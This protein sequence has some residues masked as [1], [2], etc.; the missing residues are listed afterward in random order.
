M[1]SLLYMLFS[2]LCCLINCIDMFVDFCTGSQFFLNTELLSYIL[3]FD[4]V[5]L[6]SLFLFLKI[7]FVC[8]CLCCLFLKDFRSILS[9]FFSKISH[10]KKLTHLKYFVS[11]HLISSYF[12]FSVKFPS[13][14]HIISTIYCHSLFMGILYG[15]VFL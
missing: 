12:I 13:F 15:I 1:F 7:S 9:C 14:G 11:L 8:L 6:P 5:S 2:V 10:W 3:I 4:G